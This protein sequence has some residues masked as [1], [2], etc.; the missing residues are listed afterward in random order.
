[1]SDIGGAVRALDD[2]DLICVHIEAPDEA[3]HQGDV[4]EK[5]KAIEEIDRHVV[6][7]LVAPPVT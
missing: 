6:A 1:M 5:V 7:P 2:V 3:S 4:K